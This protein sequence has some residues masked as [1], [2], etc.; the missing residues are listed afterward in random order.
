MLTIARLTLQEI[1]R[2]RILHITLLLTILFLALYGTGIH[3]AFGSISALSPLRSVI[4]PEFL[5]LGLFFGSF[6][7]SF[8][9]IMSSVGSISSEIESGT[10]QA[11]AARPIRR[12]EILMGK[13]WGYAGVLMVFAIIFYCSVILILQYAT[14][15]HVPLKVS[16]VLL[17]A[18]QPLVLLAVTTFGTTFLPTLANGVAV[19][20]LY[21]LGVLGGMI[22]QIGFMVKNQTLLQIGIISSLLMPADSLY[23]RIVSS[24][25]ATPGVNLSAYYLGPFGSGSE[26]SNAMLIYT[27]L[28][29]I[30]FLF[31]GVRTFSR[32][33]L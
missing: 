1:V 18:V 20:M 16:T 29:I 15:L 10:M 23:R 2:K 3:Y 13:F 31:L 12:S 25:L 24:F 33:D 4:V 9:A 6:L 14:G 19:F 32:R 11:I 30:L 26:P 27:G 8:L 17:Y 5:S 21:M 7:I 28:Y 22:E